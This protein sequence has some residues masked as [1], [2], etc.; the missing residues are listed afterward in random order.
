MTSG[1]ASLYNTEPGSPNAYN[2]GSSW[3]P[4]ANVYS[5]TAVTV[6]SDARAKTDIADSDLGLAF[7]KKLRPVS[8]RLKVGINEVED[9]DEA[10]GPFLPGQHP[11]KLKA[12][13]GTRTHYGLLAQEVKEALGSKDAAMWILQDK[14]DPDSGQAL[15]YEELIAPLIK[16]VQELSEVVTRQQAQI[17]ALTAKPDQGSASAAL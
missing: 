2:L 15:R 4:W 8:Y 16:A 17:D 3:Y 9:D 1:I 12:I 10:V 6:T 5:A 11:K 14:N 13:P 7:I